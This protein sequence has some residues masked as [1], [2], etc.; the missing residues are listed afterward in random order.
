MMIIQRFPSTR[1]IKWENMN[2]NVRKDYNWDEV[3]LHKSHG[4][5]GIL[6]HEDLLEIR[7]D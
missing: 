7:Y 6:K 1:D 2:R 3:M 4:W 5:K